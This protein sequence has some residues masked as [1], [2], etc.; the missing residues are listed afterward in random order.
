MPSRFVFGAY[1]WVVGIASVLMVVFGPQVFGL[2]PLDATWHGNSSSW[3]I[4]VLLLGMACIAAV[5][6]RLPDPL[7]R[8]RALLGFG[9]VHLLFALAPSLWILIVWGNDSRGTLFLQPA[10]GMTIFML[11]RWL[12]IEGP[13]EKTD[14]IVTKL[15]GDPPPQVESPLRVAY[16]REI[17]E[18]ASQAERNRLAREL[19][20]SIKQEIFAMHTSAATAQE[21]FDS[22]PDGARRALEQVRVSARDAVVEMDAMLDQLRA[23][24]LSLAGLVAAL[25]RQCDALAVRTGAT[26]TRTMGVMPPEDGLPPGVTQAFFR[27]AQE[28]LANVARHARA[29]HVTVSLGWKERRF[30]LLIEDDGQGFEVGRGAV[31]GGMGMANMRARAKDIGGD[32]VINSAPGKG[33]K[34]CAAVSVLPYYA[35]GWPQWWKAH[36]GLQVALIGLGVV[37]CLALIEV[38]GGLVRSYRR[39]VDDP[40]MLAVLI[41]LFVPSTVASIWRAIRKHR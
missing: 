5:L 4:A 8:R 41:V 39:L 18:A 21:R 13:S 12:L 14:R 17:R 30:Q 24:P 3:I 40:V 15:F 27:I 34:V 25:E 19:H 35:D 9:A 20:D 10:V 37:L 38:F 32:V 28:A 26:V 1:A 7:V 11:A 33:T 2:A 31:A 6:G 36:R 23:T 16:E 29:S 22:D